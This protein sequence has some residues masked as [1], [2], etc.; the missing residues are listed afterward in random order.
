MI[1]PLT[2]EIYVAV[3]LIMYGIYLISTY[4]LLIYYSNK[5]IRKRFW[6]IIIET[7]F[8]MFQLIIAYYFSYKLASGYIPIYFILFVIIGCYIYIIFLKKRF[9]RILNKFL[10][11]IKKH[12][13]VIKYS[14]LSLFFSRT[15]VNIIR[16]V[17]VNLHLTISKPAKKGVFPQEITAKSR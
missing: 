10:Q 7:I 15:I 14:L 8:C 2:E 12:N 11:I 1:R 13:K 3:Y 9:R 5:L 16:K 17:F 6:R 4:D